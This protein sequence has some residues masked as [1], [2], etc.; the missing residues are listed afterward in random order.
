MKCRYLGD[1]KDSFK[2]DYHDHLT[3]EL[4]FG[5]LTVALMMTPDNGGNDGRMSPDRFPA[6]DE[7]RQF[8][9]DLRES[10]D[11][12]D[13]EALPSVTQALYRVMLHRGC[14]YFTNDNRTEYFSGFDTVRNQII[15]LDPDNGF[16]PERSWSQKHACYGDV[17]AVLGQVSDESIVTVFQH[18]RRKSFPDDFARIRERLGGVY[19]T[20]IYWHSLMFVAVAKSRHP[21]V[22]VIAANRKYAAD[23]PV[24]VIV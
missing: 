21:I 15:L 2:W 4:G 19:S 20:A 8:C 9:R 22:R 16:E 24:T 5:L 6:R 13:V 14:S 10:G 23:R 11:A 18:H 1:A 3:T 17:E 12:E 7:V